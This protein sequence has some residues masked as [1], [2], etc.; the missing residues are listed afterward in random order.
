MRHFANVP[1]LKK[2]RPLRGGEPVVRTTVELPE[3]LWYAVK[4]SLPPDETLRDLLIRL[5]QAEL[6]RKGKS[7]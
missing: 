7:R 2:E 3:K 4:E 5:L 6:R 1:K